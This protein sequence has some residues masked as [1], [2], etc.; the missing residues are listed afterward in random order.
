MNESQW[1]DLSAIFYEKEHLALFDIAY[2]PYAT[3]DIESELVGIR[4]FK[5]CKLEFFLTYSSG[6]QF[7]NCCNDV[8]ALFICIN[9]T[10]CLNNVKGL[11]SVL[12]R[13]NYSFSSLQGSRIIDEIIS[14]R[15][16]DLERENK[17]VYL[18][19]SKLRNDIVQKLQIEGVNQHY[20]DFLLIQKG[21]YLFLDL[22]KDEMNLLKSHGIYTSS[23]GRVN[24][25]SINSSNI[26]YFIEKTSLILKNKK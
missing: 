26:K 23:D 2:L 12:N 6:K 21:I 7:L 1:K 11:I 17:R 14:N 15:I 25:T 5:E 3:G 22:T 18:R 13:A 16:T 9:D 8:G 19:I 20:L 10:E 24:I 4:V